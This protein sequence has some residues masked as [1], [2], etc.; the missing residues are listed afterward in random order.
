[1]RVRF[2]RGTSLGGVNN[3]ANPGDVRDLPDSQ[4]TAFVAAGRAVVVAE[5]PASLKNAID[6]V[7]QAHAAMV[8]SSTTPPAPAPATKRARARSKD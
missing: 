8:A 4:A 3:D 6:A 7:A 2:V 1:M 5:E